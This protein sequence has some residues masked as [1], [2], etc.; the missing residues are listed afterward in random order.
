MNEPDTS[1]RSVVQGRSPRSFGQM[2]AIGV[3]VAAGVAG[4][5]LVL[6]LVNPTTTYHFSPLLLSAAPS[7]VVRMLAEKA[8]PWR[9]T[10]VT[11]AVGVVFAGIVTVILQLADALRGPVLAAD[12]TAVAGSALAETLIAL[13]IGAVLGGL[14]AAIRWT[15]TD[16]TRGPG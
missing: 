1:V 6:A 12:L 5:W 15:R 14:I 13:T 10:L 11:V 16:R 3:W 2:L 4:L 9:K 7:V 8:L